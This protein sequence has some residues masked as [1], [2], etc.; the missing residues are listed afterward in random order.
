MSRYSGSSGMFSLLSDFVWDAAT[1]FEEVVVTVGVETT[2]V[3]AAWVYWA[4]TGGLPS[5]KTLICLP[6]IGPE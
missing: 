1:K 6:V 4:I 2:G 3:T 5:L